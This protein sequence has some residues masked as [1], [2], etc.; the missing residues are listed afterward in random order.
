MKRFAILSLL[1]VAACGEDPAAPVPCGSLPQVTVNT[2]ETTTATACFTDANGDMLSYTATSSAPAVAT[3]SISGTSVTVRGVAPGSAS[4]T[5]TAR[6][7]GGLEAQQSFQVMV[8]NRAPQP[9]GTMPPVTVP[10]GQSNPV[11]A[12][13]YFTEP[14]GETLAYSATSSPPSVAS[15]SVAGSTVTVT[16]LAKGTANVTVTA[17]DPGGL[18][19]TQTFQATVPNRAPEAGDPIPDMEVFVGDSEEVDASDHFTDPDG[20]RLT[21]EARSSRSGVATV[22]VSGS[23]VIVEAVAQGSARV[24]VT[25]SD[26]EGLDARQTFEVTV[27]NRAPVSVGTIPDMEVDPDSEEAVDVSVYFTDPDGDR[28][29]YGASSSRSSTARASVS[30]N[31]VTVTGVAKGTATVTVTARDPAGSTARQ[32][33]E[34]TVRNRAPKPVGTIADREV[35]AEDTEVV[36]VAAYFTDPDG[37]RLTYTAESSRPATA[38]VS[39]S[40]SVVT[41]TGVARG[42]ATVTVTARDPEGLGATQVFL[43]TVPNRAPVA[44]GRIPD[45]TVQADDEEDVDVAAYFRDPDGDRLAFTAESSSRD[46]ARVSMSGSVVTV[47]GVAKGSATVT[48]TARDPRGLEATQTFRVTVPNRAPEA[49][50]TI[51]DRTVG[52]D[53]PEVVDVLAYFRDPD[54]DRL[55]FT[56]ESSS[57]ATV[58][59]RVSGSTVTITAVAQG[60]AD[61]TVT[62]RDPEGASAVQTFEVEVANRAPVPVG[63]IADRELS[64]DEEEDVDVA[65]YFRDPDGD[66]LAFTAQSSSTDK[67][68][69]SVSGSVVTVRGVAKGSATV[70]VTATDPGGL[71]ATQTFQVTV[72][73]RSPVPVGTIPDRKVVENDAEVVDVDTSF[74]DPDGDRLTY[75]ASSSRPAT[76]RVSV[77][78]SRVTIT[79]VAKGTAEITVTARDPSQASAD[80]TFEVRVVTVDQ[81]VLEELY[82]SLGGSNWTTNTNWK[83]DARLNTWHGVTTNA[84]E[85][86]VRLELQANGLTGSIPASIGRLRTLEYLNLSENRVAS[87]PSE[88]PL[89]GDARVSLDDDAGFM[90]HA[91]PDPPERR[92]RGGPQRSGSAV[93]GASMS[94]RSTGISGA[95]PRELGSLSN[96]EYLNL[97]QNSL[98]GGIPGTL[99]EL[100]RLEVLDLALNFLDGPIPSGLGNL[101]DLDFLQLCCNR[102]T[103]SIP[104]ELGNLSSLQYLSLGRNGLTGIIPPRL[105]NLSRNLSQ[106]LWLSENS[107]TGEIPPQLG[108]LNSLERL[109]LDN[110]ELTGPIPSG[111]G[112]LSSLLSLFVHAN[113]SLSGPL[114]SALDGLSLEHFYYSTTN[115]CVPADPALRAWLNGIND[116][117]GTG[118]DCL[119]RLTN[120]PANDNRPVWS[121]PDG[122]RIAF[123]SY[124]DRNWEI[125][126]MDADDGGN[127]KRLTN[128]NN[129]ND[130]RPEW[131]DDGSQIAFWSDRD[132]N[133][134]VYT[135]N[136]GGSDPRNRTNNVANDYRPKWSPDGSRIAF[137]SN[138]GGNWEIY[139]MDDDGGNL[140]NLTKDGDTDFRP[141]WSPNGRRI[142]FQSNRE[143]NREIYAM[144]ADD[145]G[146]LVRL[147]DNV[148]DDRRPVWSPDGSRIAFQS[149]RDGNWE[150]YAMDADRRGNLVRLTDNVAIDQRPEWS[151]DGTRIAFE[152]NRGGNW[153]IYAMDAD[154]RGNLVPLTYNVA[155]DRR[156]KWSPDGS[157]IA[158][159][160]YRYG[161]NWNIYVVQVK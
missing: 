92:R 161:S 55:T 140:E 114:P 72:A 48:V 90:R 155:E 83:T 33:F 70:T 35:E 87:S 38:Q 19:A 97:R 58:R 28:L 115:L 152:S 121:L 86:V 153:E 120:N 101:P 112:N 127:Q 137:Q 17:T 67:V 73:N 22:S 132:G 23:T 103:G 111:L 12:S 79:A 77:S 9:R 159:E 149:N 123:E 42:I 128:N 139:A 100:K 7:P 63:R 130:L 157:R 60:T 30:G 154:R 107:L 61:I 74:T 160:S 10:A 147:T 15:V 2:G 8:P 69:V 32:T 109:G 134:E 129:F 71:S 57:R 119:K 45:R 56:A 117:R 27:P 49:V 51:P 148:A 62:A 135:M 24:T 75:E 44:V 93:G 88:A 37:D 91:L 85:R 113:D 106:G 144:D 59:V 126:A 64:A 141:T 143:G 34:V 26:P 102:L 18:S 11:D 65:A 116:H 151:P 98:T 95:I 136:A 66:R 29:T 96:L 46:N 122:S 31:T 21:Y 76:A 16:A 158:F 14:D 52:V 89:L 94:F 104:S 68:R 5:V 125:Y 41:V 81:A 40:G 124:R 4:V 99:A 110:N 84:A 82:D 146:N 39:A 36:N 47:R 138:R 78:G 1:A 20:D 54:G 150:I 145:G 156:P 3:A 43:V 105:G 50:G 25:A 108:N 13:S 53:E 6:D 131:N 133:R 80:Q 142:A 118:V